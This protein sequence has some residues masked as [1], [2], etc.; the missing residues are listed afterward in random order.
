L[1]SAVII[2]SGVFSACERKLD[3]IRNADVLLLPSV[4]AKNSTTIFTDSGKIQLTMS[5]KIMESYNNVEQPYS[6]FRSGIRVSFFEGNDTQAG[7]VFSKYAKYIEKKKLWELKDSVVVVNESNERLETEQLFWD[8]E[9]DLIYTDRFITITS[10]DQT[11]MGT[12]FE[13]DHRLT[14]RKIKNVKAT[15]YLKEEEQ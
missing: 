7:T 2:L 15:I 11:V 14:R 5:F 13:S 6:E 1:I 8:Q 10:E 3:T 12:G 9:K 4:T